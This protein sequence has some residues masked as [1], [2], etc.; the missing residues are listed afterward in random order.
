MPLFT[1]HIFISHVW[2]YSNDYQ[3][4]VS[5]LRGNPYFSFND[6]SISKEKSLTDQRISDDRLKALLEEQIK[7]ASVVLVPLGVYASYHK[8]IDTE[9]SI[10]RRLNKPIIGIRPWGQKKVTSL[11]IVYCDEIVGWNTASITQAIYHYARAK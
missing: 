6:Y 3:R 10:A 7:H 8:W 4:L 11:R 5:L 2:R 9:L 1:Y